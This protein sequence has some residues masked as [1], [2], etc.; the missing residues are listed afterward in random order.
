MTHV[1]DRP[2]W[3]ALTSAWADRSQGTA[4]VRQLDPAFGP[5]AA[6]ADRAAPSLTDLTPGPDGLWIVEREPFNAPEGFIIARQATLNQML[7][8]SV[9]PGAVDFDIIPLTDA[10][11]PEMLTLARLT[12]PGPFAARTHELSAFIGIRH[13]GRLVAIAGERMRMPG[14]AEVS[15]VCTHPDFRGRGYAPGLMRQVMQRILDRGEQPFLHTYRD[16][17]IAIRLYE[18]LGFEYRATMRLTILDK[19]D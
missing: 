14:F 3:N 7:A 15:A 12:K 18:S 9:T 13:E 10:D 2:V 6:A 4:A 17:P 5:F 16:N 8:K 1:L 11:G 19:P